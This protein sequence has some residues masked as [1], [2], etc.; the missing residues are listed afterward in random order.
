VH[1]PAFLRFSYLRASRYL[2]AHKR[3]PEGPL[4][5]L[6][7]WVA[8]QTLGFEAAAMAGAPPSTPMQVR[9]C[10]MWAWVSCLECARCLY[11][12]PALGYLPSSG[13]RGAQLVVL[14]WL[15]FMCARV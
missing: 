15:A 6:L 1:A 9:S 4:A 7:P 11:S 13:S 2:A 3:R 12:H 5:D 8:E 14:S 10:I